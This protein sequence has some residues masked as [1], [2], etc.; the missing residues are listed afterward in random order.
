MD[1]TFGHRYMVLVLEYVAIMWFELDLHF[2]HYKFTFYA[3]IFENVSASMSDI[4]ESS[5]AILLSSAVL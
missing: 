4:L 1:F 5:A 2:I 3:T